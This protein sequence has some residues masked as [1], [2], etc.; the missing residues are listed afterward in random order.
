MRRLVVWMWT[1]GEDVR[2][3]IR[4]LRCMKS[5]LA[6]LH[7]IERSCHYR[8]ESSPNCSVELESTENFGLDFCQA[9]IA[10]WSGNT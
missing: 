10:S 4:S 1:D 7:S 5:H 3:T 6:D 9:L 8:D 2:Q